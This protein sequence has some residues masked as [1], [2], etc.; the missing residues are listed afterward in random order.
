M[1]RGGASNTREEVLMP[2]NRIE[3]IGVPAG[4]RPRRALLIS[5]LLVGLAVLVLVGSLAVLWTAGVAR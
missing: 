5:R 4:M 3:I 1:R 2:T